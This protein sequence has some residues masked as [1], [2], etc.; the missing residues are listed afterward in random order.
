MNILI[1]GADGFIGKNLLHHL[2][3]RT[4]HQ[5]LKYCKG[6]ELIDLVDKIQNSDVIVHLAAV[7]RTDDLSNFAKIN[8][9]LTEIICKQIEASPKP[10]AL[11]FTSSLQS[12]HD[13][14]YGKSKHLAESVIKNLCKR[15]NT[16]ATIFRLPGVFGKWCRPNYNNV[17]ATFCHNIAHNLPIEIHQP[18]K[19][20]PL[21][22]IDD[23]VESILDSIATHTPGLNFKEVAPE[24]KTSLN[25]LAEII[26]CFKELQPTLSSP[27]FCNP[28]V[29]PLYST[30]LSYLPIA[31]SSYPI[32]GHSDY[33]GTF[34]EM[35][36]LPDA[37]QISYLTAEPGVT[38][39]GH[40]HH[41]KVEKFL[42]VKGFAHF[43]FSN[44]ITHEKYEIKTSGADPQIVQTFPGWSH[45]ITN[46]GN[47][48]MIAIVW[49]S[50]IFDPNRPDT[51]KMDI[52]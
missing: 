18:N 13:T 26:I 17:V 39:G 2:T 25:D 46:I 31:E 16:S 47:D 48:E 44:L 7:N 15:K 38:R 5:I 19:I 11:I 24:F 49:S 28:I 52:L 27:S 20:I 3:H 10:I 1:T 41:S 36:K 29:R 9:G 32:A 40:F 43:R 33:R 4:S 12:T 35:M 23:V 14:P 22:Y 42:I 6:D 51:I 8:Q 45:D 30:F 34:V 21:V 37:G 50:E